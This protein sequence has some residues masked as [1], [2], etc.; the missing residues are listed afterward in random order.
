MLVFLFMKWMLISSL[1]LRIFIISHFWKGYVIYEM[2]FF[3]R[4]LSLIPS[5][6]VK[7]FWGEVGHFS[8]YNLYVILFTLNGWV[9]IS[10][11]NDFLFLKMFTCFNHFT[12]GAYVHLNCFVLSFIKKSKLFS[13]IHK[14]HAFNVHPILK[15]SLILII[16][17]L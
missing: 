11:H 1:N 2:F 3:K 4:I 5:F 9:F 14:I 15:K 12:A 7:T 6:L 13:S 17:H 16:F 8:S 10:V